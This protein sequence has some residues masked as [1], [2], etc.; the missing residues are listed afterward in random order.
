MPPPSLIILK[1]ALMPSTNTEKSPPVGLLVLVTTASTR[2]SVSVTPGAVTGTCLLRSAP[3]NEPAVVPPRGIVEGDLLF[4]PL[5]AHAAPT[6]A[7]ITP[8]TR[9]LTRMCCP[10]PERPQLSRS[11]VRRLTLTPCLASR[12]G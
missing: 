11:S 3:L 2:I 12:D 7:T 8:T 10:P 1:Y 5:L 6:N 9:V 4:E